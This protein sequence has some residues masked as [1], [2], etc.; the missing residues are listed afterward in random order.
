MSGLRN[1]AKA[2]LLMAVAAALCR[3]VSFSKEIFVA[4]VFGAGVVTDAYALAMLIPALGMALFVQAVRRSFLVQHPK[5]ALQGDQAAQQFTNRFLTNLFLAS[6]VVACGVSAVLR[7]TWF[8]IIAGDDPSVVQ[9]SYSLVVPAAWLIVPM[10]MIGGLTAAL[11]AQGRFSLPQLTAAIPTICVI[12]VVVFS[13]AESG[14]AGLISGL[15]VGCVLQSLLLAV[16]VR[17]LGHRFHWDTGL[18]T[19]TFNLIWTFAAPL[20]VLDLISQGNVFVDRAMASYLETGKVAV[21][22]WSA[23][24]KDVLSG[25]VIASMLAVLLPH[26]SRQAAEGGTD[27][28]GRSCGTIM[29]Y[30]AILLFPVSALLCIC[31]PPVFSYF[32]IGQLDE[33]TTRAMAFCLAAYGLGLFADM[34]STTFYQALM[35]MG[36]LRVLLLLG[37]FASFVPNIVFNLLLIGPWGEVGLALSTSLVGLLTLVMN[38]LVLRR[39]VAIENERRN[40]RVIFG[41]LLA[42]GV[43]GAI[44]CGVLHSARYLWADQPWGEL[45]G[46]LLAALVSLAVYAM[47]LFVYPGSQDARAAWAEIRFKSPSDPS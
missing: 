35:T 12:M 43:I 31:C 13:G 16:M 25:T 40:L 24:I 20:I 37:V 2:G 4:Y 14:A 29:R 45:A 7:F 38:Y 39:C 41:A 33:K 1:V 8:Y 26:F 18:R 36:K 5:F 19:P 3:V 46:A 27:E 17:G 44:G 22:T 28:M 32:D 47:F 21:L 42:T 9:V 34:V 6:V 10:A 11:N 15:F 30:A 23:L